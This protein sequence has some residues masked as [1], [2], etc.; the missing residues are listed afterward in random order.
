MFLARKIEG[1]GLA[2]INLPPLSYFYFTFLRNPSA[3]ITP[4]IIA[5]IV[6]P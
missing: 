4:D 5:K 6:L 2:Q 3:V 1:D